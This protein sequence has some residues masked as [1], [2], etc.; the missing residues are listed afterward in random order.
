MTT[1]F[2]AKLLSVRFPVM[3]VTGT[4]ELLAP[5]ESS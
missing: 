2:P 1:L 3:D 5:R 4:L